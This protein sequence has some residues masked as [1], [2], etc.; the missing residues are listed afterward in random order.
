MRGLYLAESA[1]LVQQARLSL[2]GNNMANLNT[3]G[4]K[5]DEA[6]LT[7]F[8]EIMQFQMRQYGG[9]G[10]PA[11]PA[12]VGSIAHSVAV[13]ETYTSFDSGPLQYTGRNLDLALTGQSFFQ[14]QTDS[15]FLYTR[16]GRFFIDGAGF[17]V[18]AEGYPVW[19]ENGP[20]LIETDQVS[21]Q[22]A[23]SIYEGDNF[24][25]RIRRVTFSE[26]AVPV[27]TGDNYFRLLEGEGIEDEIGQVW[28]GFLEG[29][30]TDL[31]RE[32]TSLIQVRRSY[33]AAQK[34]MITYDS[35]LQK[36]AN[37]LGSLG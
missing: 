27:K 22:S 12:A 36:A 21:I 28:T 34:V 33:E 37:D 25:G 24:I 1:M 14:V 16:N 4:Y 2:I 19:G 6:V 10:Y 29:S 35:L 15:G 11:F 7:S 30:N 31:V 18:T 13:K 20:L 17:L 9:A 23:G 8:A 26:E 5:R 3:A 32:M